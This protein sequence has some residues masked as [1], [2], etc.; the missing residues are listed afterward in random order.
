M[1]CFC[2][3]LLT[4][5][6]SLPSSI[7]RVVSSSDI[8]FRNYL[9]FEKFLFDILGKENATMQGKFTVFTDLWDGVCCLKAELS[10]CLDGFVNNDFTKVGVAS[11]TLVEKESLIT[12]VKVTLT[13]LSVRF[14]CPSR[15]LNKKRLPSRIA[16]LDGF[17]LTLAVSGA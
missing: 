15:S 6:Q 11:L 13:N 17:V 10:R 12:I 3:T 1:S 7:K 2:Q 14:P 4:P 16:S 8:T 9:Q 5:R